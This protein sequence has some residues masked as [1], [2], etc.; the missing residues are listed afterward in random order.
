MHGILCR[1]DTDDDT[2]TRCASYS[3]DI[4]HYKARTGPG[5]AVL[6]ELNVARKACNHS[7]AG[8]GSHWQSQYRHARK[9]IWMTQAHNRK[10]DITGA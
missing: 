6:T 4:M 9:G 2:V 1:S 8:K 7:R 10:P 3:F 5:L